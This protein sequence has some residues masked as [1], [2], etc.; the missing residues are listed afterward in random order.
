MSGYRYNY[1]ALL[2]A[3]ANAANFKPL[4]D[5]AGTADFTNQAVGLLEQKGLTLDD[6]IN[7]TPDA[8]SNAGGSTVT[9][10]Q[11]IANLTEADTAAARGIHWG[12]DHDDTIGRSFLDKIA[13]LTDEQ[14]GA[15]THTTD[16]QLEKLYTSGFGRGGDAEGLDYWK[17]RLSSGEMDIRDVAESF[18]Q[19]EEASY[20]SGY[21]DE[22]GREADESGLAYWMSEGAITDGTLADVGALKT[23]ADGD[24]TPDWA[25]TDSSGDF[26]RILQHT[27]D[28]N[29]QKETNV[30]NRLSAELGLHSN[31]RQREGGTLWDGT[32]VQGDASL[33][34]PDGSTVFT[35]ANNEMV[36]RM[37]G[38]SDLG[39]QEVADKV[40][41]Q[42]ASKYMGDYGGGINDGGATGIHRILS[43]AEMGNVIGEGPDQQWIANQ[44][45]LA[46]TADDYLPKVEYNEDG[47]IKSESNVWSLLK[48]GTQD[49]KEPDVPDPIDPTDPTD[50]TDPSD[51]SDPSDPGVI[52]KTDTPVESMPELTSDVQDTSSYG[53]SKEAFDNAAA[54]I[55]TPTPD[56]FIRNSQ[57]MTTGESAKGV[58]LRRS[59]K[60]KTG[61]T[62]LGT[63]QLGR[64]L[65]IKSLNI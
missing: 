14:L 42:S 53:A 26:T 12:A 65:Q 28:A 29:E 27:G 35:A 62:A 22:Y 39:A 49:Y 6:A 36:Q 32:V 48:P 54:G 25:Q 57:M 61:E 16:Q 3:N 41:M 33:Q 23:D 31:K 15:S 40:K 1:N 64:E 4:T 2:N 55:D 44:D 7:F 9:A 13:G 19:S 43:E 11:N 8:I 18:S 63:K 60:F 59:K 5:V 50:P 38:T 37:M 34:R 47:T 45:T 46:K 30:R 51:P 52:T 17:E 10:M 21:H 24:G 58:R 20:R 56:M